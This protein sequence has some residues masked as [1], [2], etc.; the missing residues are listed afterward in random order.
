[1]TDEITEEIREIR[2]RL[3]AEQDNDVTKI[4]ADLRA[5][6]ATDGRAYVSFPKRPPRP[7][8]SLDLPTPSIVDAATTPSASN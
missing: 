6:Q 2:H 4:F 3:A 1:M 7:L 5:R 8:A